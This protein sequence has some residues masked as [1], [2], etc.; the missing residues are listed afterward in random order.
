M[1]SLAMINLALTCL[2]PPALTLLA[3]AMTPL[4]ASMRTG[5]SISSCRS[6][7]SYSSS[8]HPAAV[9]QQLQHAAIMHNQAAVDTE[10]FVRDATGA[11]R[12]ARG[13]AGAAIG[14]ATEAQVAVAM[15]DNMG[16]DS[17]DAARFKSA[18]WSSR[19]SNGWCAA[20][21]DRAMRQ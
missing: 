4:A 21:F 14:G 7:S 20:A 5:H 15:V 16:M 17:A 19:S 13:A 10:H 8:P 2:R 1:M 6:I 18:P 12:G 11:A 3:A 9:H